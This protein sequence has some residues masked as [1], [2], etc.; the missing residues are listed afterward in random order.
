MRGIIFSLL[1]IGALPLILKQPYIG[2]LAWSWIGYMNPHRLVWG[3]ASRLPWAMIV[4]VG[5][6]VGLLLSREPKRFLWTPVTIVYLLFVLWMCLTTFFALAPDAAWEEWDRMIKVQLMTVVTIMVMGRRERLQALIWVIVLSIGFWGIKGGLWAILIADGQYLVWGPPK[7]FFAGNNG[8]AL[9]LIMTL[10][11]MRYLQLQTES[12]WGRRGLSL[13]MILMTVAILCSYSRGAFLGL[14]VMGLFLWLKSPQKGLIGLAMLLLVP[15]MLLFMPAKWFE[16]IDSIRTY[17]QD[18]AAMARINSW[19]FLYRVAE[20]RPFLGG[21]FNVYT[22]HALWYRYPVPNPDD[23][24]DAHS[25]Y[26]EVLGEHGFIG[27]GLFLT[28]GCLAWRTASWISY[29]ARARPSLLWAGDLAAMVQVSLVGYAIT[30]AF[31]GMAY[32]DL[33][34]HLI[35][36]LVLAKELVAEELSKPPE[37]VP[38]LEPGVVAA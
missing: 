7:S 36:I 34:Y 2:I 22:N 14:V 33:Y 26:F 32:F 10:P 31:L 12:T 6:L 20:D 27:L 11:L 4:A 21:G 23:V 3:F 1:V 16:R 9:A 25:I 18:G 13:A 8:L 17:E 19:W 29:Y 35:A 15:A 5:T 30:G 37:D 24:R 28:L 38:Q